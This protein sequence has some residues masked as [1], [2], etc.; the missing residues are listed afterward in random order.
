MGHK[1][2]LPAVVFMVSV[3]ALTFG[4]GEQETP[5]D[6]T[7]HVALSAPITGDWSEY[8]VNFQ[9]SVE[10]AIEKI[11]ADGGVLDGRTFRL[12]VGDTRGN[13]QEAATLAQRWTSD[14]TIVAQIGAFSSSSSMAAQPIY[15]E[16]GM[17]QLSPTASH[18][19]Y[20]G[21]SPWSFGIV[22][23]QAGEG[24]FN[25]AFAYNDLGLRRVAVLH[26]NNDWGIDTAKH[27]SDAFAEFGGE[28]VDT[29]F[30]FDGESDFTAVL[31]KL[32]DSD[33]DG[34]FIASFYNDGAAINIQRDRLG[35][36]VP[37]LGPTSLYSP[38]LIELGGP[39]VEGLYTATG[40]FSEDPQP[41]VREYVE[42]FSERY[43]EAPNFHA[44]LAYDA[45]MLLADAIERAGSADRQAIRD[46]LAT[47]SDYPGLAGS[48]T[49]T[50]RGD[51]NKGYSKLTIRDGRFVPY[52]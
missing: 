45:M 25:A 15:D 39:A 11:N 8:G 36:D 49:F 1:I 38:Q 47:T 3:A 33:A 34:V 16:A 4:A 17:V 27:F 14:G 40:F 37:V 20:A 6:G 9:R 30:Y 32:R 35:W 44:A 21:G 10:M 13:P 29:E 52:E 26:L 5:D 18:A 42:G 12:S 23:T 28:V 51:A 43:G 24:P 41:A 7:I 48:V 46:A 19:D 50:D 22:G 2:Y 31:T